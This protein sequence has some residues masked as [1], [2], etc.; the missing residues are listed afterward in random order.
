MFM[1][2]QGC[3][4]EIENVSFRGEPPEVNPGKIEFLSLAGGDDEVRA[5]GGQ[6]RSGAGARGP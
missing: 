4:M 6:R 5:Q 1:L 3:L 2:R